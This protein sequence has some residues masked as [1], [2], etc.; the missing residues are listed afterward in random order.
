[1][2]VSARNK[3]IVFIAK[4]FQMKLIKYI[5][6]AFLINGATSLQAMDINNNNLSLISGKKRSADSDD[7]QSPLAT[8]ACKITAPFANAEL[9]LTQE[10]TNIY[11]NDL[12]TLKS[13][14]R[15]TYQALIKYPLVYCYK[16]GENA[17]LLN[18][19]SLDGGP[20]T[21]A[22]TPELTKA[23]NAAQTLGICLAQLNPV[24]KIPILEGKLA[25]ILLARAIIELHHNDNSST[26]DIVREKVINEYIKFSKEQR[27]QYR[28]DTKEYILIPD[29]C[30]NREL[31]PLRAIKFTCTREHIAQ[32][33][34][35]QELPCITPDIINKMTDYLLHRACATYR[36]NNV[37]DPDFVK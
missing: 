20:L 28:D 25:P 1:M 33:I 12:N 6:L 16:V 31:Q 35:A 32:L 15:K 26:P 30:L 11:T 21:S 37:R 2:A 5:G 18:Q 22:S 29:T 7:H 13:S 27:T 10:V 23:L 4:G 3:K 9:A 17:Y 8:L 24:D 36:N 19:I 34:N 14:F